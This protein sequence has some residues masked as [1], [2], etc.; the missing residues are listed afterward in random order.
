MATLNVD[1]IKVNGNTISSTDTDGDINLTP[2]GTGS[3]VASKAD[4]NG[5]AIDG[6]TIG[7]TTPAAG[8][9]TDMAFNSGYG[10]V[11]TAYGCRAWVNF[12]GTLA[13]TSGSSYGPDAPPADFSSPNPIRASGNVSSITDNGTGDYTVNFTTAMPDE[14]YA[15]SA[16]VGGQEVAD[17]DWDRIISIHG[18]STSTVRVRTLNNDSDVFTDNTHNSIAIF[19]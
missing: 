3:V 16:T 1:N 11:A 7:G 17:N 2:N 12:D 6:T 5:G 13:M 15:V 14:N 8:S 19:R 9:F 4:I 18:I 10:S